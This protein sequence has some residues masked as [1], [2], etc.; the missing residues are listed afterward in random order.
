VSVSVTKA[1][2]AALTSSNDIY[3]TR[4]CPNRGTR[5]SYISIGWADGLCAG[6]ICIHVYVYM[7]IHIHV[8]ICIHIHIFIH[9]FIYICIYIYIY[10]CII[11][12]IYIYIHMY[13]KALLTP[14]HTQEALDNGIRTL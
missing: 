5:H 14:V 7:Y 9:V 11:Y 12:Y 10:T 6:Y 8:Y 4:V 2:T 1:L 3:Q 13:D